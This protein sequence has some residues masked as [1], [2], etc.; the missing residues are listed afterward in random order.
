MDAP[1]RCLDTERIAPDTFL[2]RRLFGEGTNP[3]AV[4][5]N[6]MVITGDEP[7]IVDTGASVARDEW[8]EDVFSLVDPADVRWIYLSHDDTD[9]T[10]NLLH[11][12]ELCPSA[13]LVTNW[14]SVER[15]A[16]D[17]PL[18]LERMRWVNDGERFTA[19]GREL[20]AALPPTF[21][22]PTT[23]GLFDTA[24][25]VYWASDSFATPV[26]HEVTDVGELDP[27][28]YREGFLQMNR[29]LS[30]WHRWLDPQKYAAHLRTVAGLG[31]TTVAS[32]HGPAL[33]G[34]QVDAA[35][36]LLSQL[37]DL[38]AAPLPGQA[39]L[40]GIV[41]AMTAAAGDPVIGAAA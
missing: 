15:L 4:F 17:H 14:F 33:H 18:P 36:D 24:T 38:P 39:E 26:P 6:S 9:H 8:T 13:T 19:G 10:G 12:L 35:L 29:V 31:A 3:V 5:L 23:R 28:F 25:G 27:D 41:Q 2:V 1:I 40:D 30:P 37:P 7:I 32:A 11:F 34:A 16:A 20:V 21:D 22:S